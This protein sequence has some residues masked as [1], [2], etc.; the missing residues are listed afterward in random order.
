MAREQD[1]TMTMTRM[2]WFE[3]KCSLIKEVEA[4]KKYQQERKAV[5]PDEVVQVSELWSFLAAS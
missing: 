3:R 2:A 4:V 5:V 1:K